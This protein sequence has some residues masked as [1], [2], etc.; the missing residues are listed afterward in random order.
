MRA[1]A[2]CVSIGRHVD[3]A[4]SGIHAAVRELVGQRATRSSSRSSSARASAATGSYCSVKVVPMVATTPIVFSSHR[5]TARRDCYDFA[6]KAST[7]V[8]VLVMR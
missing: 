1:S 7:S 5:R 4:G 8:M 6:K 3:D 2:G